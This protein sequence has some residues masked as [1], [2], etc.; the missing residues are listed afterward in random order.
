MLGDIG[1]S[2]SPNVICY[3]FLTIINGT[4]YN[5]YPTLTIGPGMAEHEILKV[6]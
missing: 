2:T 4:L 5:C 3:W 6:T 1:R